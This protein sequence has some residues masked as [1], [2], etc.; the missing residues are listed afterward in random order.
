MHF[1]GSLCH[2]NSA[3]AKREDMK[4]EEKEELDWYVVRPRIEFEMFLKK[5]NKSSVNF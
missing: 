2:F 1:W 4:E 5:K 3:K